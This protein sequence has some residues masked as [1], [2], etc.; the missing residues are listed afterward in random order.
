LFIVGATTGASSVL[1]A[2]ALIYGEVARTILIFYMLPV[3]T[4][5]F[6]RLIVGDR[7]TLTRALTIVCGLTG[8]IV[9]LGYR[10]GIPIPSTLPEWM[11]VASSLLFALAIT[12]M[13]VTRALPDFEKIV[14]Q[15]LTGALFAIVLTELPEIAAHG[16]PERAVVIAV[17]PWAAAAAFLWILPGMWMNFW[18]ARW[19]SPGLVGILMLTEVL[20]GVLS[21]HLLADETIGPYEL[22]GGALIL[23]AGAAD[24]LVHNPGRMRLWR[25]AGR[26]TER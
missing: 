1:F 16:T 23:G 12:F 26:A 3:W 15:F 10:G 7:I 9:I 11:T 25:R 13:R 21:A 6:G 24:I 20:F 2:D 8:L 19:L 22:I 4:T 14:I 18:G 17:L 5:L